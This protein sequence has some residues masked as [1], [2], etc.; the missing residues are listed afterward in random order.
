MFFNLLHNIR[1][2]NKSFKK[3]SCFAKSLYISSCK[4]VFNTAGVE[5]RAEM[6]G[7]LTKDDY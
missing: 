3:K 1:F 2:F 4:L 5:S 6:I 7:D